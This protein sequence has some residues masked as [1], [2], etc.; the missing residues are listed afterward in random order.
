MGLG[1]HLVR[2]SKSQGDVSLSLT[3]KEHLFGMQV[4]VC[5]THMI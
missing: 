1:L 2:L 4:I 5:L 3:K